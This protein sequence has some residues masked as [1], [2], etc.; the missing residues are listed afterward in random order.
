MV[1][2]HESPV[3]VVSRRVMRGFD[4]TMFDKYCS[5]SKMPSY[6]IARLADIGIATLRRWRRGTASPQVDLLARTVEVIGKRMEDVVIIPADERYPGDLRVLKG[7]LQPILGRMAGVSTSTVALVESGQ[8]NLTASTAA[9]LAGA[10]DVPIDIYKAAHER[11][12][13]RPFGAPI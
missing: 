13:R 1:S 3:R 5:D 2:R 8:I 6:E 11:A 7:L 10:L 12:R 9:K 4:P